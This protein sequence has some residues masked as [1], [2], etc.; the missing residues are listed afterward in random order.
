MTAIDLLIVGGAVF[1]AWSYWRT[2]R[3]VGAK[4]F[5]T[6]RVL[7]LSGLSIFAL[8]FALDLYIMH[9][10]PLSMPMADVMAIMNE[11]HREFEWLVAIVTAGSIATGFVL[12]NRGLKDFALGRRNPRIEPRATAEF[13]GSSSVSIELLG[14]SLLVA[15]AVF[16][17][18]LVTPLGIAG[19]VPYVALVLIG[20][21]YPRRDH[22]F[23]LAAVAS[24]LTVAGYFLSP[25]AG[26]SWM[27]LTNRGLALFAIWVVAILLNN[28][29][30][31]ENAL[32]RSE[33]S[34]IDAQR[35]GDL[36]SWEWDIATGAIHWTEQ[37][38]RIFGFEPEQFEPTYEAFLK[39][40][41]PDDRQSVEDAVN[42]C[43]ET[44]EP[45][46]IE[47][48]IVLPDGSQR[49]V[50]EMGEV[51]Y[52]AA[53]TPVRMAGA[54]QDVTERKQAE[55]E[56]TQ[57]GRIVE[58][59]LNE[60]YV[61]DSETLRFS[62][63]NL[64]ARRNLGYSMEELSRLTPV[65]IK[66]EYT[67][68]SFE[69]A[70]G[71]LRDGGKDKI[72][73]ETVHERKDGTVYDVEVHLQLRRGE[74]PEVFVAIIND[75]TERKRAEEEIRDL[76]RDLERRVEDRSR[77]LYDNQ[78][79]L[80][81]VLSS[82]RVGTWTRDFVDDSVFWDEHTEAIFGLA[83]GTF[84]GTVATFL[85]LV[86]PDDHDGIL[87]ALARV[88]EDQRPYDLDYRILCPDGGVRHVATRA[89]IVRDGDG[90]PTQ[91]SGVILDITERKK[92]EQALLVSERR[93]RELVAH[94]KA[95]VAVYEAVD[96]GADF[97]FKDF[98]RA[99]ERIDDIR[100]GDVVGR[101]L[102]E[103]FPGVEEFGLLEVLRRVW[104]T[105]ESER[106]PLEF[107]EDDR[108]QGWRDNY[109]FKLPDGEVVAVY[110]DLTKEKQQEIALRESEERLRA[111]MD[112][113]PVFIALKDTQGRYLTINRGFENLNDI[114]TGDVLGKAVHDLIPAEY[115]DAF[116]AADMKVLETG[117]TSET[118]NRSITADGERIFNVIR[119]PVHGDRGDIVALG[120]IAVDVSERIESEKA[121]RASE[122]R[123]RDIVETAVEGIVQAT[124][125]GKLLS[126]NPAAA[127]ILGYDSVE[128]LMREVG[129]S[130]TFYVEP[131]ERE[132][133]VDKLETEGRALGFES[134][135]R[136]RDGEII[137]VV[138]NV[139]AVRDNSGE[140]VRF[141]G[142]FYDITERLRAEK[143]ERESEAKSEFLASMTHELR[144]PMNAILG[145]AQLLEMPASDPL[146]DQQRESIRQI[147]AG[148]GHLL[149]LI[150][151]ILDLSKI[152][153][154]NLGIS[155]EAV[156][157]D[158]V[159]RESLDLAR[160][161]AARRGIKIRS[162]P[163]G[164]PVPAV[165]AD[166]TRFKQ[167]LL[168]LLSNAIKYNREDGDVVLKAEPT[169][170]GNLRLTV[171]DTGPGI[172]EKR[173]HELFQPF[174]R[175][176]LEASEIPGTGIGL[177]ITRKLVEGMGGCMGLDSEEG[178]G[179]SFWFELPLAPE[180]ARPATA[181]TAPTEP[182]LSRE[183]VRTVLYVEDNP[184]NLQLMQAL[185][186]RLPKVEMLSAHTGELGLEMAEAH[187]PDAI[188]M[189]INL[190]GI[191]G[192]QALDRLKVS[193][194]TV[195]FRSSP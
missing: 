182:G 22:I 108:T 68:Q 126:A 115:A 114:E 16:L 183:D 97:V 15:G 41:H 23:I 169:G 43:L 67:L 54:V 44:G 140:V 186:G 152:E 134:Q 153:S 63:V 102:T 86:H 100:R 133:I 119:F 82:A 184:A 120:S 49:R 135:I 112:N 176:G 127:R 8:F 61:F 132:A 155:P 179:S 101:R 139:R 163:K 151:D 48:R 95:G 71:P 188:L 17:F 175:L 89:T 75:I 161:L 110:D 141:D 69:A 9:A 187:H 34:L 122:E 158:D 160:D 18:D 181:E 58:E 31:A 195:T 79:R 124:P 157:S 1:C 193:K 20:V 84:D 99:G 74:H 55:G 62:S 146:T 12:S 51:Y 137:R 185:L 171:S 35:I 131:G 38:Y 90:N 178:K 11:F 88:K 5:N 52:D 93:Y 143:A 46:G 96:D 45:Y 36:G 128:Q 180:D 76:N 174:S 148:G 177:T 92:T 73:F 27:A 2:Y 156:V 117:E 123:Y 28:R 109:V 25:T 172:P 94:M 70:I 142:F 98:N 56:R 39:T 26:V 33:E 42:R 47:H 166:S 189:D 72:V 21:W 30:R 32:H 64:G 57:L 66:P 77:E 81:I 87:A 164:A 50:H 14:L 13:V 24:A 59:S 145:F 154:G 149:T 29:G 80:N 170:D 147:L 165:W 190:P 10:L 40:I 3:Y 136:R 65:D 4:Y 116:H 130:R 129:D 138:E 150:D 6:G 191:D 121:L 60:V 37:I 53:G 85:E 113:A 118:L 192:F 83:P 144:T 104:R 7:V 194:K 78:R 125:D 91:V 167:V 173:R 168:N 162:L 19:G 107:Y 106:F 103:V 111:I 159:I 105:G